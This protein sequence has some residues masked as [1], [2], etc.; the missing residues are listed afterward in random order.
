MQGVDLGEVGAE[1]EG[2]EFVLV[3]AATV[4]HHEQRQEQQQGRGGE[5]GEEAAGL[6]G[7]V[8]ECGGGW[9]ELVAR[10]PHPNPLPAYRARGNEEWR[11]RGD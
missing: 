4:P 10:N 9:V 1:G 6:G 7:I 8:A 11:A 2:A 3:A 5:K